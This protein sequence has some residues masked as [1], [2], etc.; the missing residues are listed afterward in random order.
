[1]TMTS[2]RPNIRHIVS[3]LATDKRHY[4]KGVY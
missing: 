3:F 2:K 1:M 4:E